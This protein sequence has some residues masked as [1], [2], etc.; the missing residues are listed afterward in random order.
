[1]GDD[2]YAL[3]VAASRAAFP[4]AAHAPVVYLVSGESQAQ[5]YAALPAAAVRGGTV[6]LTRPDGI[7]RVT[8]AEVDRLAPDRIVLVGGTTTLGPAVA[9]EAARH[10]TT[11][12]RVDGGGRDGHLARPDP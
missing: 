7:P 3:A 2:R 4:G 12:E 10:A 6:L 1:M 5:G 9:R 8:A 11:V